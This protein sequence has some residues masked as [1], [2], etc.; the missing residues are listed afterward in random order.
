MELSP[1]LEA[2]QNVSRLWWKAKF[3][4]CLQKRPTL[5][6]IL[7]LKIPVHTSKPDLFI[8]H[9]IIMIMSMRVADKSLTL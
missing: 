1:S 3:H 4:D 5:V 8:I 7:F 6:L 2:D 9:F